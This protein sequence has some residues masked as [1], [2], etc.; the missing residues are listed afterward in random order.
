M[1][2]KSFSP[3]FLLSAI[4]KGAYDCIA[5]PVDDPTLDSLLERL[6][7]ERKTLA[8]SNRHPGP[9]NK[10]EDGMVVGRF[11][12]IIEI[13]KTAG[14]VAETMP[15]FLSGAKVVLARN[16]LPKRFTRLP[17]GQVLLWPSTAPLS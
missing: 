16:C 3:D 9:K 4:A 13:L 6:E 7:D 8:G 12:E 2:S 1:L 17:V 11:L 5:K 15:P 10:G 14:A